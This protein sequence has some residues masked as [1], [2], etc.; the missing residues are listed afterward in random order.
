MWLVKASA[1]VHAPEKQTPPSEHVDT[2][3]RVV[4][5]LDGGE[6]S[7][8]CGGVGVLGKDRML[9]PRRATGSILGDTWK[10]NVARD[11]RF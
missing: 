11:S 6:Q 8:R 5:W 9:R 3:V 1:P 10:A 7:G 4:R 2:R